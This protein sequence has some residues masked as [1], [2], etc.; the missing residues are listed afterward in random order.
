MIHLISSEIL[1]LF[2]GSGQFIY[3]NLKRL[4][5]SSLKTQGFQNYPFDFLLCKLTSNSIF[6]H[7]NCLKYLEKEFTSWLYILFSCLFLLFKNCINRWL[8]R[9][10][11]KKNSENNLSKVYSVLKSTSTMSGPLVHIHLKILHWIQM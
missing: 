1:K 8:P 10:L 2:Q 3:I 4:C 11:W 5:F 9:M 7:L 6:E